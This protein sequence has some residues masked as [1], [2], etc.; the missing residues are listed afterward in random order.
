MHLHIG[1]NNVI[2]RALSN[3]ANTTV[4]S[5]EEF[6]TSRINFSSHYSLVSVSAFD[7]NWKN[8]II[9][10]GDFL[11]S[12][13]KKKISS[14]VRFVYISTA[15]ALE[16]MC[17]ERH[18]IYVDN[19]NWIYKNLS[20]HFSNS[21]CIYVPNIIPDISPGVSPLIDKYLFNLRKGIVQFDLNLESTWNFVDAAS[22]APCIESYTLAGGHYLLRSDKQISVADF[23]KI[24]KKRLSSAVK[25]E[26]GLKNKIYPE[27]CGSSI[28]FKTIEL[29]LN[30]N[31][32]LDKMVQ[33]YVE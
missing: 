8:N 25:V 20:K 22:L 28:N 17:A 5:T 24:A 6:I 29:Y 10:T 26:V 16:K 23:L 2:G 30:D 11:T 12:C 1:K 15:R 32:W 14:D 4:L 21:S 13:I 3:M 27:I 18:R 19:K 33:A 7:P 31:E 9:Q